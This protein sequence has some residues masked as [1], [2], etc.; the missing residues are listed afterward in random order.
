MKNFVLIVLASI[1]MASGQY[2][3]GLVTNT[4]YVGLALA[5]GNGSGGVNPGPT[6]C[7]E[8]IRNVSPYFGIG[9]HIDYSWLS[10]K[11]PTNRT[12]E[13]SMGMH[14]IDVSLVPKA[15]YPFSKE[16]SGCV[17]LDP[18]LYLPYFYYI[19]GSSSQTSV[20]P[21]FGLTSGLSFRYQ[22]FAFVLKFKT[23]FAEIFQKGYSNIFSKENTLNWMT[24]SVG[25]TL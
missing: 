11:K 12:E 17:E 5:I 4:A 24:F 25:I 13:F 20:R 6:I 15:L 16:A 19:L 21:F 3:E 23:M 9:G 14:V 18:G 1:S 10:A 2:F 8:P 22:S 7:L